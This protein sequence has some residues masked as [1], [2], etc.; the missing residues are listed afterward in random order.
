MALNEQDGNFVVLRHA[1]R[2]FSIYSH[3]KPNEI[4]VKEGE[5]VNVGKVLDYIGHT[6]WSIVP[7]L[8]FMVFRFLKSKPARDLESLEP[9]WKK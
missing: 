6:G 7:H 3:L 4:N 2:E 5:T 8:H 9:R 1:N